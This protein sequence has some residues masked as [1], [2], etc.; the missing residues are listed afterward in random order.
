MQTLGA[1][2]MRA[3]ITIDDA[4]YRQALE[5]ADFDKTELF[6]EA[7]R[8]FIRVKAAQRLAALGGA[9]SEMPDVSRR[10]DMPETGEL[11]R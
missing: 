4:L 9:A 11:K 3:T 6:Q 8:T 10:R 5:L 7:I 1:F 2:T